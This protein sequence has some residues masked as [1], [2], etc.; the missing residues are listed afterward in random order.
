MNTLCMPMHSLKYLIFVIVVI[1][2]VVQVLQQQVEPVH[3]HSWH[4]RHQ[5]ESYQRLKLCKKAEVQA[6]PPRLDKYVCKKTQR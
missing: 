5:H 1:I 6:C 2:V 4:P 3:L